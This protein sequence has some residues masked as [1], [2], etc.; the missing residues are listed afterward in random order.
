MSIYLINPNFKSSAVYP[1]IRSSPIYMYIYK[2]LYMIAINIQVHFSC[3]NCDHIN[4][5]SSQDIYIYI[6]M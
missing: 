5:L 6:Y 1:N 3:V 2:H 4:K